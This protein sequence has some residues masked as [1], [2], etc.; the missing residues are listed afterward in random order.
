MR[1]YGGKTRQGKVVAEH[2]NDRVKGLD[3]YDLFCGGLGVSSR[4]IGAK[5]QTLN[6]LN[7]PL[8]RMYEF[9]IDS[10][11]EVSHSEEI[12]V[13]AVANPNHPL[14]A[15]FTIGLQWGG[16]YGRG[17]G[18]YGKTYK[19]GRGNYT[20]EFINSTTRKLRKLIDP[21]FTNLDFSVFSSVKD[22]VVYL[23]PP[24]HDVDT[25]PYL[26]DCEGFNTRGFVEFS[27]ELTSNN[28]VFI[29]HNKPEMF[30]EKFSV[31]HEFGNTNAM[32]P[33]K[34]MFEYLLISK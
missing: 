19:D 6:D 2:I 26:V 34:E 9:I 21:V 16:C 10:G 28:T 12:R 32:N 5:S 22:S 3:Y 7:E 27:N 15:M 24:Y 33:A 11:Y 18:L 23:D 13:E 14:H 4:I 8:I 30:K 25:T 20:N 17:I 1:Y 29:T 31:V